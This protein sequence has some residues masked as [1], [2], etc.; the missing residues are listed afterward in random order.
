ME[1]VKTPLSP[2][3]TDA[4][5][6][7]IRHIYD[8]PAL[9]DCTPSLKCAFRYNA[10][11][12]KGSEATWKEQYPDLVGYLRDSMPSFDPTSIRTAAR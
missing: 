1:P 4:Q 5:F 11:R 10:G 7:A 6:R 8:I 9:L 12:L 2:P 3:L